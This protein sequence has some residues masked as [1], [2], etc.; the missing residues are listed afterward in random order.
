M[1]DGS[2]TE[3]LRPIEERCWYQ[4]SARAG[5]YWHEN[6]SG[7]WVHKNA[8]QF[9]RW[10]KL[11]GVSAGLSKEDREAGMVMS[12]MDALL[13]HLETERLLDYAGG[14]AGWK[15]GVHEINRDQV[16]VTH[17][18]ELVVPKAPERVPV[19]PKWD[20]AAWG[21]PVLG[22]FLEKL[23][24]GVDHDGEKEES[25]EQLSRVLTWLWHF[26]GSLYKG[27]Y[28]TGLALGIAGEPKCGKT[29]FAH[30]VQVLAGGIVARPY[31][32]MTGADNFNEEMLEAALLLVDDENS[33]TNIQSR[34]KFGA[35]IKQ[36]VATQGV[37]I[38]AM[39][40]KAML[41]KPIQ[42]LMVLVNLEPERL[43]VLPP[44]DTDIR[45][46]LL[47]VKGYRKEMP[48]PTRTPDEQR[49][50]WNTL[51]G[52]LPHFLH[53]LLHVYSPS[54]GDLDRFGPKHWQHPEVLSELAK[55]NPEE[56]T[57]E[58][59]D[60]MLKQS[61]HILRGDL[62]RLATVQRTQVEELFESGEQSIT[63]WIG[64]AAEFRA[65]LLCDGEDAPLSSFERREVRPSAYLGRDLNALSRRMPE[66]FIMSRTP[67]TGERVIALLPGGEA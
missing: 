7:R 38:R 33:D 64:T 63:G 15:S 28:S 9:G 54:V 14:L 21:Y 20:A 55:L 47:I 24:N 22:T 45:D 10:L 32:Y 25:C 3:V 49:T 53:W 19:S 61:P 4:P 57:L 6:Q 16:L 39:H 43:Q 26:L 18:L 30:V 46:K 13:T 17:E 36:L 35:E 52:E 58:F 8:S 1:I 12:P 66:R 51:I 65:V 34:L 50:F 2:Q 27:Q 59:V 67:G 5:V 44:I 23:F 29:L 40:Q 41:M 42:R 11:Q 37:R 60:R 31:R 56:R 62:M 48:M